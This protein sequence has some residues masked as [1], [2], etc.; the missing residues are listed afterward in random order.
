MPTIKR[1][2]FKNT[3]QKAVLG[4]FGR[5]AKPGPNPAGKRRPLRGVIGPRVD[6][7][8][9]KQ[10]E[11]SFR[12]LFDSNPVPMIVCSLD[13]ERMLGVFCPSQ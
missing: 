10:R 1:R 5:P 2:T 12:L 4:I 6:I 3:G 8:E 9:L 7:T 13:G 11:A